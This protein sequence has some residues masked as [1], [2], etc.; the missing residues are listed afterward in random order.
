MTSATGAAAAAILLTLTACGTALPT[1]APTATPSLPAVPA[2]GPTPA[3]AETES[4]TAPED[5][6]A[7]EPAAPASP[8]PPT[9]PG[10]AL[11][12]VE[13]LEVKGRAPRTGYD[14][15]LFGSGWV[16]TDRNGCDTRNDMLARDLV[17][18]TFKPGTRDCVVLTGTLADPYSG[19]TI[20]FVRGQ[21]TSTAVQIDHVVALSDAWQKGAQQWDEARR[22][23]FANDPLNLLAVDGPLNAQKGDGDTATWLP[24][25]KGFRCAYVARQVAVKVMYAV[26]VTPAERDAMVRV[27]ADCPAEPLPG[28]DAPVQALPAPP[29]P[30]PAPVPA[31]APAPVAPAPAPAPTPPAPAPAPE[32]VS[33]ANCSE[34]RAAGAAP[35][36]VGDPGYGTHLDRDRDGIGCE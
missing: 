17:D 5:G 31:P 19:T 34:A 3:P 28:G 20:A 24:P 18:E 14:R 4:P 21:A 22:V 25:H 15:D 12:A 10:T 9:A 16:D 33:F 35:V 23:T 36:R 27:L 1:T 32:T 2:A 30:A 13:L 29:T 11:A 6:A 26:W 8:E 7:V